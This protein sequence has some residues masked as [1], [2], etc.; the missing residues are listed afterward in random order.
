MEITQTTFD[1][2]DDLPPTIYKYRSW[3]EDY[4][5]EILKEQ[6]V[7]MA[8]PSSF[9]DPLDCKLQKRYDLLTGQDIYNKY[10][11]DSKRENPIWT[12]QQHR[13]YA[14]DWSKKSPLR[15]PEYIKKIQKTHFVEF[16]KRMGVLSLT[17]NP[18]IIR[19]WEE[20]AENHQGFCV[21]F[22][23]KKMFKHLGGGGKVFY[24]EQ[25]PVI[26]PFDSIEKEHL[27]QVFSK[28]TKWSFEEEYRT[29]KFYSH[30][31]TIQDRKIN[32]PKDCYK[33]LIFGAHMSETNREEIIL[34]CKEQNLDVEFFVEKNNEDNEIKIEKMGR[35]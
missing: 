25:L 20:Y 1:K 31:A 9:D 18:A 16:D 24:C 33:E 15:D 14:R 3:T 28:E 7:F 35:C 5:K 8:Q 22:E 23:P 21:G 10:L 12:R 4:H 32:L 6:I 30:P 2:L 11:E 17:G 34:V 19:M 29:H 13:K 27:T 26:L